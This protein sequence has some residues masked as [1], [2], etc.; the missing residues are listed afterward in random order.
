MQDEGFFTAMARE[1]HPVDLMCLYL[2]H[3]SLQEIPG[4]LADPETL[5]FEHLDHRVGD[6]NRWRHDDAE[7]FSLAIEKKVHGRRYGLECR[8]YFLAGEP[9]ADAVIPYGASID[10]PRFMHHLRTH[11][12]TAARDWD[13]D[14]YT[15]VGDLR[16]S[17][18]LF[19]NHRELWFQINRGPIVTR[20]TKPVPRARRRLVTGRL[21]G[22]R[23]G[24][25]KRAL[26]AGNAVFPDRHDAVAGTSPEARAYRRYL[27]GLRNP[28]PL[29]ARRPGHPG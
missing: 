10:L 9:Y 13:F 18:I 25:K 21:Q 24:A 12:A 20:Q 27:A 5:S 11:Y 17:V 7:T 1:T 16:E 26:D 2:L 8:I 6:A 22:N 4:L 14:V 29:R 23:F 15:D 3:G 19:G 28:P